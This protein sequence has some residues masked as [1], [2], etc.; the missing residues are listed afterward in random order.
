MVSGLA[1]RVGGG[2]GGGGGGGG[3]GAAA[4]FFLH[5]PRASTAARVIM[6]AQYFILRCFTSS[7]SMRARSR[8]CRLHPKARNSGASLGAP[9][10]TTYWGAK[11]VRVRFLLCLPTAVAERTA[12][13]EC[14]T[15]LNSSSAACCGR[16]GSTGAAGFHLPAWSRS[17]Q[18]RCGWTGRQ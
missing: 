5:A 18:S 4:C 15:T 8:A 10:I 17:G 9:A 3:G 14:E 12:G 16:T 6:R 13:L 11:P 2:A 1:L 7:S